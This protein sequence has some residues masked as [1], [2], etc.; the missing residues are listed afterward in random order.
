M[1]KQLPPNP[2][3]THLKG[4]ARELQRAVRSGD[5]TSIARVRS[6]HP[7]PPTAYSTFTLR[8]AQLTLAREYG[9]DGWHDL[10]T[11]VGERM[12]DQRDLHRWFGVQ[13]NNQV[14]SQIDSS[15]V[16]PS[17]PL[18]DREQLLYAAYAS[19]FHWRKVGTVAHHARGEYLISRAAILAGMNDRALHHARRC[20]ELVEGNR[21]V[22][23]DWD[24]AF[25]L[26]AV[27]RAEVAN[28]DRE[29]AE[30]TLRQAIEAAA[31]VADDEDRQIVEGELNREPWFGLR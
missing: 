16:T 26:E 29:T 30:E 21:G 25:A 5:T 19:A 10:N 6:A 15:V 11:E 4:Q 22:T 14:W 7:S 8:D 28:G 18:S 2:S 3:I 31:A 12:V 23:A 17:S 27:A 24:L 1:T 13:I 20:L 9:F